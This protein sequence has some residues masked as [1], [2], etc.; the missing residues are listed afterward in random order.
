MPQHDPESIPTSLVRERVAR[1]PTR[2]TQCGRAPFMRVKHTRC[3]CWCL[4]AC[5]LACLLLG[6]AVSVKSCSALL[7]L[8]A[9]VGQRDGRQKKSRFDG[10]MGR[11]EIAFALPLPYPMQGTASNVAPP[12]RNSRTLSPNPAP[13]GNT[14]VR[15]LVRA[16]C[17]PVVRGA[18]RGDLGV[19]GRLTLLLAG[20]VRAWGRPM[21]GTMPTGSPLLRLFLE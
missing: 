15:S 11:W 21:P 6:G 12:P 14:G 17:R 4:L 13:L 5:L 19:L 20:L 7:C 18:H 3:Y 16:L 9:L 1:E 2:R 8:W 10:L